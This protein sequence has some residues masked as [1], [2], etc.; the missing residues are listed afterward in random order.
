[1]QPVCLKVDWVW[2]ILYQLSPSDRNQWI[3]IR[4]YSFGQS[5][6]ERAL[7]ICLIGYWLRALG[8]SL[9][10]R[11]WWYFTYVTVL[12]LGWS[13]F[14]F[15]FPS[16]HSW[17]SLCSELGASISVIKK[18]T[19]V[20]SFLYPFYLDNVLILQN[21]IFSLITESF[22]EFKNKTMN[23]NSW[24]WDILSRWDC[25]DDLP[26]FPFLILYSRYIRHHSLTS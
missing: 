12:P 9:S 13:D 16:L 14:R 15:L 17:T 23:L 8:S 26:E 25:K 4:N 18:E 20:Q 11:R 22:I 19:S 3:K 2:H 5:R 10:D 6:T 7:L 1:M 21:T 24:N